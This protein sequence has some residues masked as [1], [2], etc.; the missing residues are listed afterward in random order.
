M[1]DDDIVTLKPQPVPEEKTGRLPSIWIIHWYQ[2]ADH[3]RLGSL[4]WLGVIIDRM[5]PLLFSRHAVGGLIPRR[6]L[7][8]RR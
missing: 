6:F 5:S 7:G 4:H 8:T 1:N 2:R 3:H